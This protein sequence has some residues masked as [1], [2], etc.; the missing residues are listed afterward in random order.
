ME[1]IQ[2][3]KLSESTKLGLFSKEELIQKYTVMETELARVIKELYKLRQLQI[4][5]EQLRLIM[6]EQLGELRDST[7]GASSERYKKPEKPKNPKSPEPRIKKPSERYPNIPVREELI[8]MHPAPDCKICG[9]LM[10]DSGMTEDSQEL[11]VIPKRYEIVE[12]KRVKYSCK[13]HCCLITAPAPPR[14][15]EGSSYSNEMVLDVA[16]SKYCDLIPIERYSE[17]AARSGLMDLPPQS[18]IEL[19]HQLADFVYG[20][21]ALIKQGVLDVRVLNADETPHK[22]LEGSDKK[23]WY[24][25]GFSTPELCFLECHDTRSGD[26]A[27]DVLLNSKCAILVTDVYSGYGK[28]IRITNETRKLQGKVLIENANCNAHARRYFFKPRIDYKEAEFYLDHYHQIYQLNS[29][30]KGKSA[31]EILELRSQMKPHFEAMREKALQE[32][33]RYPSKGK[34]GRAL[35]YFLE[36]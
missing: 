35:N 11:T 5:D 33:P 7:F 36:N 20:S 15:T 24:L 28:A 32:L 27:S 17:M 23:T 34:Y 18:L 16:L 31:P 13:S 6:E 3:G 30:S 8:V 12:K 19:T 10:E 26:I 21:Y 25:W 22:M 4:T 29:D 9:D 1:Q 2:L 14:I